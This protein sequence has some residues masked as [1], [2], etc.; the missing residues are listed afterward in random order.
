MLRLLYTNT[1]GLKSYSTS[2]GVASNMVSLLP[3]KKDTATACMNIED[4]GTQRLTV[5][6]HPSTAMN[7]FGR[8]Y[9]IHSLGTCSK[10]MLG[11][12]RSYISVCGHE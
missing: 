10:H 5:R 4:S 9:L 11:L 2:Q 1:E 12:Q 7:P 6:L 8:M 3:N